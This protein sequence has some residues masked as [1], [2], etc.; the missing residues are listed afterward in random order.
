M[1]SADIIEGLPM[2]GVEEVGIL[3]DGTGECV[4]GEISGENIGADDEDTICGD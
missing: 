4:M 2:D 1:P 3:G